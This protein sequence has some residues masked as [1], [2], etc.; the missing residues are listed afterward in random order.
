MRA[1]AVMRAAAAVVRAVDVIVEV[2]AIG[3]GNWLTVNE[4][5]EETI[6][7]CTNKRQ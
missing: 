3:S 1:A 4:G 7:L 6:R 2:E 5:D